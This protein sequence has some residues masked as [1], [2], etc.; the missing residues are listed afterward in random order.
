MAATTLPL[1][2]ILPIMAPFPRDRAQRDLQDEALGELQS[3]R[4]FA[5]LDDV[6][7]E[8]NI[9]I[10]VV[11]DPMQEPLLRGDWQ[12]PSQVRQYRLLVFEVDGHVCVESI[13]RSASAEADFTAEEI[14]RLSQRHAIT[15]L[16]LEVNALL[17]LSNI[18]RPGSISADVGY[19]FI[20]NE[21]SGKTMP[22][23]AEHLFSAV[24][25]S[26]QLGWPTLY[27]PGFLHGWNWLRG[28]GA[29]ADGI[30]VGRL[31]RALAAVSHL[32][33]PDL[34]KTSSIDLVW[35]LLGLE[36]LYSKGNVGLKEQ[37]LGKTEALLGPRTENKKA[38]GIVYDF[39]SRV[40]H[41]D[42]DLPLRF[43]EFDAVQKFE[44]FHDEL[45]R[46]EK[47]ALA[48]LLATLQWMVIHNTIEL[49]FEYALLSN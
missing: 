40:L 42:V 27:K 38:F 5:P 1:T 29:L 34:K 37:L 18:L 19:A 49:K 11:D 8:S 31:G 28:S 43:T 13:R 6:F 21:R 12:A 47:L 36:A 17:L 35:I 26:Q 16:Q 33:A 23:F 41:G 48:V 25:A 7:G 32:T 3:V 46:N 30:G 9:H 44:D 39:R 15:C 45:S 2:L 24:N 4:S 14:V 20:E 10:R 22:F